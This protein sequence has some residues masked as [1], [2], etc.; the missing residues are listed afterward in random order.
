MSQAVFEF[1]LVVAVAEW[2]RAVIAIEQPRDGG[3]IIGRRDP[4]AI[5]RGA[6]LHG[7]RELHGRHREP[8]H[9]VI[10]RLRRTRFSP[11]DERVERR[12]VR[13]HHGGE[14]QL[15]T[16]PANRPVDHVAVDPAQAMLT[17]RPEL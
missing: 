11:A 7:A 6:R 14:E 16:V 9:Q 4:H 5:G 17:A 12:G 2:S 15:A 1:A 10:A 3:N 13:C 8:P